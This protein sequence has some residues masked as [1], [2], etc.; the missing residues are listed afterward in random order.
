MESS[1]ITTIT[2]L[3]G[4]AKDGKRE[5]FDNITIRAGDMISIVGPTGSGKTAFINDIEVF[6]C[7]DTVTGRTILVNGNVP[8]DEMVR[9]P[10]KKP[11]ALITQNT[12]CLA[13]LAVGD[14]LEMHVKARKIP[15]KSRTMSTIKLAN[16]FT[17][18]KI[19]AA[20]RMTS[21]SGGQT[22]S[23]LIADAISVSSAPIILLDEV[24]SGGIFKENVIASLKNNNKA[25]LFVTH[26]PLLALLSDRRIV[27]R[28][29]A[30]ETILEPNG[31]EKKILS[32][33]SGMDS[34]LS[35]MREKIR[36][37]EL[38]KEVPLS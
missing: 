14:F 13:D 10:A 1:A 20:M 23:L 26:D 5:S 16:E 37:G 21:L 7:G 4:K 34:F 38:L 2:V 22:R 18:E 32:Q 33:I 12:K 30:V 8:P 11:I 19:T 25:V 3:P 36:A 29:G 17:G 28:N 24:E 31:C 35:R 6:A 27:M 15:D 9:D